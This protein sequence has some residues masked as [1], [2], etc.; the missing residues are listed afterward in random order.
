MT[1]IYEQFA[2]DDTNNIIEKAPS[3]N[4]GKDANLNPPTFNVYEELIQQDNLEQD[5]QVKKSLQ[6]VMAKDPDMVGEGLQ[7][8]KELG[9]SK[10]FALDSDE[11]IKLMK[12]RKKMKNLEDLKLAKKNPVLYKQLT[13][14]TFAALAYDNLPNLANSENLWNSLI[15]L[16]ENGWQGVRKGILSRELGMI[17]NRLRANQVKF[18]SVEKGFDLNYVPTEQDKKDYERIKEINETIAN[19][20][21]DGVGLVEGSG[22]FF[23]QYGSSIPEAALTGLATYKTKLEAGAALGAAFG[24]GTDNSMMGRFVFGTGGATIG[25]FIGLFTGWN[26]FQNKLTYDTFQIEGGH[27]WLELRDRGL[28]ME[29]ARIA[30]NA[31]GTV[32]AIIEKIGLGFIANPYAKALAGAKGT[33][34]RSG[35]A[36]TPFLKSLQNFRIHLKSLTLTIIF[37]TCLGL[38]FTNKISVP[39]LGTFSSSTD[40]N[41][42]QGRTQGATRGTAAWPEWTKINSPIEMVYKAPIRSIYLVFAPFPWDVNRLRHLIGMFDAILYM[43]LSYLILT[44]IRSIWNDPVLRIFLLILL[45]YIFVF[46]IGVGN[47][48]TGIRHRSKF[49]VIFI[50]LA[51]PLLK[52]FIFKTK[53]SKLK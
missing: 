13:D 45:S 26:A 15:S 10:N 9:L 50:L 47:F 18:I 19:Y 46:G 11:A 24:G 51:A 20:D 35:L 52:R 23:G 17:A 43:Y 49:V 4:I 48:G 28:S 39:Y 8:T 29:E 1:N 12:E 5:L 25:N 6:A 31:V 34:V 14:P 38:Y 2:Q 16:P 37:L 41:N 21:A 3:Q 36:N 40:V 27:S 30:S 7:L 22:Y 32:N 53:Q 44:N 42:L 33:F